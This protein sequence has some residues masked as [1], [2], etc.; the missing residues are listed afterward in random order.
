M[1]FLLLA[2]VDPAPMAKQTPRQLRVEISKF[3]Y[4]GGNHATYRP[5]LDYRNG[6]AQPAAY[7]RTAGALFD[8]RKRTRISRMRAI[9][10]G[11]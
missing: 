11:D 8:Q 4:F 7:V 1:A 5:V 10:F 9:F 6:P 2:R 3:L